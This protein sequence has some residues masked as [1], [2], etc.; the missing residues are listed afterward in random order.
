MNDVRVFKINRVVSYIIKNKT[1]CQKS[2]SRRKTKFSP[3]W[4]D[5]VSVQT[6]FEKQKFFFLK[7]DPLVSNMMACWG[8]SCFY[9]STQS[10]A[11]SLRCKPLCSYFPFRWP[12]IEWTCRWLFA[13][14][15]RP[16]SVSKKSN[17]GFVRHIASSIAIK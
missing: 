5:G 12:C 14:S 17:T 11:H 6:T 15:S 4:I 2:R 3:R 10:L 13:I 1:N 16:S 9:Y 7:S 8:H